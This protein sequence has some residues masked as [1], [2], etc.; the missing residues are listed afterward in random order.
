MNTVGSG[1]MEKIEHFA[2]Y[3][4]DNVSS[5]NEYFIVLC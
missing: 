1:R 4:S 3:C 2:R 5:G